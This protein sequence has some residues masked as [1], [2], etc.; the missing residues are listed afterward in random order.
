MERK[1]PPLLS[2][3]DFERKVFMETMET[4]VDGRFKEKTKEEENH[5]CDRIETIVKIVNRL[6]RTEADGFYVEDGKQRKVCRCSNCSHSRQADADFLL[7][8]LNE[9]SAK[10]GDKRRLATFRREKSKTWEIK[11]I[12]PRDRG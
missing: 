3:E 7:G 5:D 6:Q 1:G 11:L 12:V 2:D 9:L 10:W 8:T 4:Y